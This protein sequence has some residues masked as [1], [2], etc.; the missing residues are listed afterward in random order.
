VWA[1]RR[2][3]RS[4]SARLTGDPSATVTAAQQPG[5]ISRAD[6]VNAIHGY[7]QVYSILHI[8]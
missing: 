2:A 4:L 8:S 5:K 7:A 1:G 3:A 6:V